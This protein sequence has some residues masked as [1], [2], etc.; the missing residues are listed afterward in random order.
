MSQTAQTKVRNTVQKCIV[1]SGS[2]AITHS[3]I[4]DASR[5]RHF[6]GVV[7]YKPCSLYTVLV[8]VNGATFL[9]RRFNGF[10]EM[11]WQKVR[12]LA[13]RSNCVRVSMSAV[14]SEVMT[15]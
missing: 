8:Y 2:I 5:A 4:S 7:G 14:F 1:E 13:I 6:L 10:I 9:F 11:L 3:T 12:K 15:I